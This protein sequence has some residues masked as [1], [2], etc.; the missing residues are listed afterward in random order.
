MIIKQVSTLIENTKGSLAEI[1]TLLKEG[2]IN[3]QAIAAFDTPEYGIL[4]L[5]VDNPELA[6]D[7]LHQNGYNV[8]LT[9]VLAVE[10]EDEKGALNDVLIALELK[11]IQLEYIYSFVYKQKCNPLMIIK[12]DDNQKAIE[13]LGENQIKI[14]RVQK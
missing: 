6:R 3:I 10:L 14:H 7:T 13:V 8:T 12:V 1:T 2:D 9:D 11:D 4:R 5:I